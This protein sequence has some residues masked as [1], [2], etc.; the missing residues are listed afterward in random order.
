M[1]LG[2]VCMPVAANPIEDVDSLKS[3]QLQSVQVVSTRAKGKT[4]MAFNNLTKKDLQ[5]VNFG[6]DIPALLSL[7][8]SVTATSDAGMGIGYSSVYVR[9]T[10]PTRI[11]VT[12]NG[13]P[14]NDSE[15]SQLYWVNM[16]DFASSVES[17]QVQ[18]G[19]GTST[20]GAGAFGATINMQTENI[21]VKPFGAIDITG[22]AYDTHKE[23]FRFGT[24]LLGGHW[25][26]QGR[27]SNISSDG[28]IDRASSSLVSYFLQG[29]YFSDNT[30]VK[31]VTFNGKEKTYMAWDYASK[32]DMEKYGRRYNPSGKYKDADGNTVFYD[33][34][35]DNYHQQHYQLIASHNLHDHWKMSAALHYT[36]GDGYYEQMK[37]GQS[38]YKYKLSNNFDDEADLVRRKHAD[39]DFFG[40]VASVN[41][42]DRDR[43][44]ISFGGGWNRYNGDHYGKVVGVWSEEFASFRSSG[45]QEFGSSDVTSKYKQLVNLSTRQL[46]NSSTT[47][48][49]NDAR[50]TDG[51][52]Y[53]KLTYELVPGLNGFVDLQYRHVAYHSQGSSQEYDSNGN[54]LPFDVDKQYDF[55]NPKFGLNYLI[56]NNH[57]VYASYAIAHKEPTRNDFE[58]MM[59]EANAVEPQQ[60]RLGDFEVGYKYQSEK[61]S[62]SANLYYMHYKNQFVLTGAQDYNGEMVARNI[63]K[64]YRMGIE[65]QAA[66][67]PFKGFRWDVNATFSRNRAKDMQ[68][69]MIDEDWNYIGTASAGDTHL[70]FSPD[71]IVNNA[72]SYEWKGL[73]AS[74]RSKFVGEQYMTNSNCR[75]YIDYD[76]SEVSAMIDKY[77]VS[78]LDISYTFKVKGLKRA[79]IGCTIYNIF[80]EEYETHGACGLYFTKGADGSPQPYHAGGWSYSVY[81]AQAPVHVL[82]HLSVEW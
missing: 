11:N 45:V 54:Q 12:A 13:I 77:F 9:G 50:K 61:F 51:N 29:G 53:V 52:I 40:A 49:D 75:S 46:V 38:L 32:A 60:E 79:T 31:L 16:G 24:G 81:S 37:T 39:S 67:T 2:I 4:P 76:G 25:G 70:A 19:V 23:T 6:K 15:S 66:L 14:L 33:N 59:A 20:N 18:R 64:S 28:Y 65:L 35:T 7:T 1:L 73:K 3:V 80:N 44:A 34:Q 69:D 82:A 42:D 72:L 63:P 5:Q 78:D 55:F 17:M 36:R 41:Y 56:D 74:L 58:D 62:A 26:F 27:L 71:V 43:L 8:P 10:D 57:S 30:V 21:G 22:G 68:L 47:Y 48:Y